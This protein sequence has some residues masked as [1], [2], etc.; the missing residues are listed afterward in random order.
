MP[1]LPNGGLTNPLWAS[2]VHWE[3]QQPTGA[4]PTYWG[5]KQIYRGT[6]Q[7]TGSLN[8]L[9]GL[10]RLT[11]G[12]THLTNLKGSWL[13][14][15]GSHP[16]TGGLRVRTNLPYQPTGG[17]TNLLKSSPTWYQTVRRPSDLLDS[18][19]SLELNCWS[20]EGPTG[21]PTDLLGSLTTYRRL[22]QPTGGSDTNDRQTD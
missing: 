19:E 13:T 12:L 20:P 10:Y 9:L 15:R 2:P 14:H 7:F 21:S 6:H 22:Y 5:P 8:N 4:I 18:L 17:L 11:V 1:H 16:L 3:P